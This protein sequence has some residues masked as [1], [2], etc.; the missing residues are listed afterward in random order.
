MKYEA[1]I[2]DLDGTIVATEHIWQ[3]ATTSILNQYLQHLS[4]AEKTNIKKYLKGMGIYESCEYLRQH[5]NKEISTEQ[6]IK[7]KAELAHQLY[8]KGLT[9]I[10][11]F[12][13]F[14]ENALQ[15]GLKTAIGTN[16]TQ[17]TVDQTIQ[18]LPLKNYFDEHIYSIDSVN[19]ACKPKPDIFLYAAQKIN[20]NPTKCIVIEDSSHG[21]QAAKAAGMYCIGINTGNDKESLQEADV[22]VNCYT[23]IDLEKLLHS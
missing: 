15:K 14:H 22:I 16:A 10:P 18:L 9:F 23:E 11:N 21:V 13:Q 20:V 2:F 19:R 17:T 12:E 3:A 6:I 4:D 1:I 8:K 5:S 7:E